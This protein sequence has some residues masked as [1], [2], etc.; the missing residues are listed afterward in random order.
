VEDSSDAYD[1]NRH[2]GQAVDTVPMDNQWAF[3][4]WF[5]GPSLDANDMMSPHYAEVRNLHANFQLTAAQVVEL[6][7]EGKKREVLKLMSLKG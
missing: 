3:G 4:K 7:L 5:Y 1:D 2:D 6:A